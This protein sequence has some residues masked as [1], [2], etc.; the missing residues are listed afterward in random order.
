MMKKIL[1]MIFVF[2][3]NASYSQNYKSYTIRNDK[4][5]CEI[6]TC[7]WCKGSGEMINTIWVSCYNC[8][9]WASSYRDI[10]GCDVCKNNKGKYEK[11]KETCFKCNGYGKLKNNYYSRENI[12]ARE[13][14]DRIVKKKR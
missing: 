6:C 12:A 2:Y 13:E 11:K 5:S 3:I 4:D 7:S 14:E 10:K 9:D 8:K 1:L